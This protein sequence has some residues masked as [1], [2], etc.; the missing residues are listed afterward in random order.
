MLIKKAMSLTMFVT[1]SK[2]LVVILQT[3]EG[4]MKEERKTTPLLQP[5]RPMVLMV[6]P[7]RQLV[8]NLKWPEMKKEEKKTQ[9]KG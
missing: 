5:R 9:S 1:M 4:K 3:K 7:M 6:T 2:Q 8:M